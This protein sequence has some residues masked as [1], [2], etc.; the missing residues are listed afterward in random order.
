M[1]FHFFRRV[2][3]WLVPIVTASI[4]SAGCATLQ[5]N[6]A[7]SQL[8]DEAVVFVARGESE[9]VFDAATLV[10]LNHNFSIALENDRIGILQTEYLAIPALQATQ[11]DSLHVDGRIE[12][13]EIRL[14]MNLDQRADDNL[15]R[16]RASVRR[17][18]G[19]AD[20]ADNVIARYWLEH[21]ASQLAEGLDSTFERE[22]S[23]RMYLDAVRSRG[24]ALP[25]SRILRAGAIVVIGLFVASLLSGVLGP[26]N[27]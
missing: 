6:T 20:E 17:V 3:P 13:L 10:F 24:A 9:Q 12:G 22:V 4:F 11:P 25:S 26:S 7:P 18:R 1:S 2:A 8:P 27:Q 16:L 5:P 23:R 21:M 19:R 15:I 14:T